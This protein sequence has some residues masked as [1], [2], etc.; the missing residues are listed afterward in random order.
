MLGS[1]QARV[2][3]GILAYFSGEPFICLTPRFAYQIWE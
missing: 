1:I 3:V 2:K